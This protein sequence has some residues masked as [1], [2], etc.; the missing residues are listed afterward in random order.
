MIS[1]DT[2]SKVKDKANLIEIIGESVSLRRQ[3]RNLVGLC[4]FHSEK[5]PSFMIRDSGESYYCFGCGASGNVLSY[6]MQTRGLSFPEAVEELASRYGVEIVYE[7]GTKEGKKPPGE[8]E[9]LYKINHLAQSFF[10]E[11]SRQAPQIFKKYTEE[12]HLV[13]EVAQTFGVGYAPERGGIVDFLRSK[14]IDDEAM[15]RA[16]LVQR[17]QMGKLMDRF[18]ARVIFPIYVDGKR[19]AGFGGRILPG[20]LDAD[21]EK[22]SPKYLNSPETEIYKKSKIL[23]GLPQASKA[24]RENGSVYLVEGYVDVIGL[25]RVGVHNVVATC[26]TAVTEEHI[27]RISHLAKRLIVLFDGDQAGRAAAAKMYPLTVN[28]GLDV[29]AIFLDPEDDP[30]TFAEKHGDKTGQVLEEIKKIPL[31]ECYVESLI[32]EYGGTNIGAAAKGKI[33]AE[34]QKHLSRIENQI[35][36]ASLTDAAAMKLKIRTEE[37]ASFVARAPTDQPKLP[38]TS[39]SKEAVSNAL[40]TVTSLPKADQELL[41]AVIAERS[42][43]EE[44]L[45]SPTVCSSAHSMTVRFLA[46]ISAILGTEHDDGHKKQALKGFLQAL[47]DDWVDLWRSA[48]K[49]GEDKRSNPTKVYKECLSTYEKSQL[50]SEVSLLSAEL[51]G[52]ISEDEKVKLAQR[53]LMLDRRLKEISLT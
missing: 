29:F 5:S 10:T 18:R 6:V 28:S 30:D 9:L 49:M 52:N 24:V 16:G 48:F 2:I 50:K 19:I 22:R 11:E 1:Q 17:N 4:P 21:R 36:R 12:R 7:S 33:G 45:C 20:L 25:W 3:G 46:G 34:L 40:V 13:G 31:F 41:R 37:L 38:A 51:A 43:I 53:K 44:A 14:K 35:E 32:D 47:G 42:L 23:F 15:I 27:K 8:G 39:D 26:G